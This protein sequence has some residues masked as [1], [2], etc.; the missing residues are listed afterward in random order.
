M[1][2]GQRELQIGDRIKCKDPDDAAEVA[3]QVG[4]DGYFWDFEYH[5]EASGT[6]YYV[7]I[8]G[9]DSGFNKTEK[10]NT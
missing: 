7:I 3:I 6:E 4:K 8:E 10:D 2:S 5:Y 9:R 1:M